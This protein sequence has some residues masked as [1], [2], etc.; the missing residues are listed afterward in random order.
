[1]NAETSPL[2]G[3]VP[4]HPDANALPGPSAEALSHAAKVQ[5]TNALYLGLICDSVDV[6]S[7]LACIVNGDMTVR[8]E[9]LV[10]GGA[11]AFACIGFAGLRA[12]KG[13]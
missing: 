7:C 11:L 6:L 1:M 9:V 8:A 13:L 10:A 12:L 2:T 5:L 4:T 3:S